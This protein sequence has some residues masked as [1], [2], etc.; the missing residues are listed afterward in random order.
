MK[1]FNFTLGP[2]EI[3]ASAI[4]GVPLI[5]TIF[6]IYNPSINSQDVF[7]TISKNL[8]LPTVFLTAF[9]SYILGNLIQGITWKY[10]LLLCSVFHQDYSYFGS[11]ILDKNNTLPKDR[12][13]EAASD[14]DFEDSL[15]FLL[16][17]KIGILKKIDWLNP[18]LAAYLKERNSPSIAT[19]ESYLANHIMHRNMSFGFLLL[20]IVLFIN[21][22]RTQNF[23]FE[24]PILAASFLFISYLT[25]FRSFSFKKWQ[26][27]E[28]LFGFYFSTDNSS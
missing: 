24:Q 9:L 17:E 2:Y 25:F 20:P 21:L 19:V 28:L 26:N 23:T 5:L 4:G 15:V 11:M 7:L 3:F 1:N 10:F 14:L 6:L 27:R 12:N 8:T 13:L 18:R 22:L 16:R